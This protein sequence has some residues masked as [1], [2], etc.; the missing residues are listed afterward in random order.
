MSDPSISPNRI[1]WPPILLALAGGGGLVLGRLIPVPWP[2]MSD[3]PARM[4]GYGFAV[5]GAGLAIWAVVTFASARANVWPTR[6]ASTLLTSGPFRIWRNPLYMAEVLLLLGAAEVMR[7]VW[8]V[9]VAGV[10]A[11]AILKLG[12]LPEE[13]HLEAKFGDDYLRYKRQSRRWF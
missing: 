11:V 8:F 10:F 7:N 12:I 13:A 5:A 9:P 1:P 3:L 6:A 2:G 4:I